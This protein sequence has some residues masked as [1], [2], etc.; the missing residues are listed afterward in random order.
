MEKWLF[1]FVS[2]P[3]VA[4]GAG[5]GARGADVRGSSDS[6]SAGRGLELAGKARGVPAGPAWSG[7]GSSLALGGSG[8]SR[9][10]DL[11]RVPA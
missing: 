4:P 7:A 8:A 10:A 9:P 3:G 2:R 5:A 1:C 11:V 6:S